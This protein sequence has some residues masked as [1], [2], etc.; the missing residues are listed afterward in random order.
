MYNISCALLAQVQKRKT[1]ERKARERW[2]YTNLRRAE[3][4]R[5]NRRH[6]V[7]RTG[8]KLGNLKQVL[9]N[10]VYVQE[11]GEPKVSDKLIEFI[12]DF[13]RKG[14]QQA[15]QYSG[16][17]K[18]CTGGKWGIAKAIFAGLKVMGL[19]RA[20]KLIRATLGCGPAVSTVKNHV[21]RV[22][23]DYKSH[24]GPVDVPGRLERAARVW[25]PVILE[26]VKAG[27]VDQGDVIPVTCGCDATPVPSRP[28]Y[29]PRRNI[30]MGLCG[31]VSPHHKC[32]LN[33]PEQI[34]NGE[35]GFHQIVRLVT[36]NVWASYI[37]VHILQPQVST[38]FP[39]PS[40]SPSI[41][42]PIA[43]P[44]PCPFSSR[45]IG[46]LQCTLI[47]MQ[48]AIAT[49][50]SHILKKFGRTSPVSLVSLCVPSW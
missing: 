1:R 10:L 23:Q 3:I 46:Y 34:A 47:C 6:K 4:R 9:N 45:L 29:C 31:P 14:A 19:P 18:K 13:A 2:M 38:T 42:I 15:R 21:R 35:V 49:T 44:I 28:Q 5:A 41:P 50:T 8:L 12:A 37:Y 20:N 33:A 26:K 48:P 7:A 43:M 36:G 17:I 27:V 30:I 32:T 40:P 24:L 11:K 25:A 16:V 39:T 22:R